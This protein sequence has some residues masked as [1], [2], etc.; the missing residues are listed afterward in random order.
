MR[1]SVHSDP[2]SLARAA[3]PD[4]PALAT[5]S[6][7]HLGTSTSTGPK[8]MSSSE[9]TRRRQ[10]I[11][12]LEKQPIQEQGYEVLPQREDNWRYVLFS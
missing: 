6:S 12:E 2:L 1:Q 9:A 3:G 8:P 11:S 7:C 4:S 10:A 5:V